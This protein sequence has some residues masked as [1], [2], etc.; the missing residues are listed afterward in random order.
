[1]ELNEKLKAL[2]AEKRIRQRQYNMAARHLARVNGQLEYLEK[3][4]ELARTGSKTKQ[5]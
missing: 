5:S 2:R 1:M 3:R 4:S